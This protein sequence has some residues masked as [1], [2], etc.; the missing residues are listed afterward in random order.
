[1]NKRKPPYLSGNAG[2]TA[3]FLQNVSAKICVSSGKTRHMVV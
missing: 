1:M 3:I 2:N